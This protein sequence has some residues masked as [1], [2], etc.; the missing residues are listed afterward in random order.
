C[1]RCHNHKFDAVSTQDYYSL[2]AVFQDIEFGHRMPQLFKTHPRKIRGEELVKKIK[3]IRNRLRSSNINHWSENWVSHV[4]VHFP[5]TKAKFVKV[6]FL[7][8]YAALDELEVYD[9]STGGKN[10]ALASQGTSIKVFNTKP[11]PRKN[12]DWLLDGDRQSFWGWA[13]K[14]AK[15]KKPFGVVLQFSK[16]QNI[17]RIEFSS[18]RA[19]IVETDYLNE[20]NIGKFRFSR[21]KIETSTDGKTWT[22]IVSTET[23]KKLSLKERGIRKKQIEKINRLAKKYFDEGPQEIFAGRFI[24]PVSTHVL[25]RG[26]PAQQGEEV[27]PETFSI[28]DSTL[29]LSDKSTG[30]Q[31]RVAFANWVV[32][33]QNPLTLRVS[34]NRLWKHVF[35]SGIVNTMDDFGHAGALPT[36]PQLLDWLA[37]RYRSNGWSTKKILRMLVVSK[38]FQQSSNQNAKGLK[39]DANAQYL[40]R[41][42]LLRIDAEALRDSMLD[43]AGSLDKRIGGKGYR[44]HANKKRYASW[45]V[46]DNA[47]PETWRRLIYQERM[48]GIDDKMFMAFD[49]PDCKQVNSKRSVSTTPIQ[50]LNLFNG[51]LVMTQSEKLAQRIEK[52]AGK[53]I[54]AQVKRIF[55]RVLCREPSKVEL[56]FSVAAV[57]KDGLPHLARVLFNTNEFSFLK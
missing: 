6:S 36:H 57:K 11:L 24:P 10:I 52:E 19:T 45:K 22:E 28:F 16:E 3:T 5:Q 49:L 14:P 39:V 29:G 33:K 43:I 17:Q 20:K 26:D 30:Q 25:H 1:A 48:R 31:R 8:G 9:S 12:K 38:T 47:S 55:L 4:Q 54:D 15:K 41:Y 42:P 18:D 44:I 56:T 21:Y 32:G 23:E 27:K 50:A 13:G 7:T 46:A 34:V 40:W 37:T 2:V 51:Q 35:G 53:N